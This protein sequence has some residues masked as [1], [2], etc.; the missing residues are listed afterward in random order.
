MT[1]AD[2]L[3]GAA[4][5]VDANTFVYNFGPHPTFGTA[6]AQFLARIE[7]GEIQGFTSAS[8]IADTA[9]RLMAEEA[10]TRFGWPR[11]G[12][13]NRLKRHPAE[14]QQLSRYRQAVDEIQLFRITILPST[15]PLVSL[16][17]DICRQTGLL[18]NDALS[19]VTMQGQGLTALASNDGDFDRVPGITRYAP[20]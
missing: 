10:I 12:I 8:V 17:V 20:V 6:C 15:A 7:Q 2:V 5:F 4:V 1:F 13:A 3:R 18:M 11:Q 14:V 16:A 9:H 19:V